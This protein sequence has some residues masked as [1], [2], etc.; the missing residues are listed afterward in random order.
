MARD[1]ARTYVAVWKDPDWRKL[2]QAAQHTYW[3]LTSNPAISYCGVLDFV[4][5]RFI[6][7]ASDLPD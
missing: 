5:G 6:E 2:T 3:M 4:P 7:L 1:H